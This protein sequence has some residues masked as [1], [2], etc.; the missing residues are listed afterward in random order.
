L[1][2]RSTETQQSL[3]SYCGRCECYLEAGRWPAGAA[4]RWW[5]HNFPHTPV[6][7]LR[8]EFADFPWEPN[9][10]ALRAWQRS[11]TGFPF[12]DAGMREQVR[13]NPPESPAFDRVWSRESRTWI[14][15][16]ATPVRFVRVRSQREGCPNLGAPSRLGG[17]LELPA[18]ERGS[19]PHAQ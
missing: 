9:R 5:L 6:Q 18:Q 2:H 7:P 15:F 4:T 3:C 14:G 1:Y 13:S 17:D 19:L 8:E 16:M 10:N 12:V 11:R